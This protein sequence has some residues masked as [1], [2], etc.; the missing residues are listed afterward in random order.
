[1]YKNIFLFSVHFMFIIV[2]QN[3]FVNKFGMFY[4]VSIWTDFDVKSTIW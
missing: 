2:Y 4:F 1:M 3:V